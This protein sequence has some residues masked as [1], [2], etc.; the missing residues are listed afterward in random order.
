MK[1]KPKQTLGRE[2]EDLAVAHLR[3]MGFRAVDRNVRT[4]FGEIDIVASRKGEYYFVEVKARQDDSRGEA[5]E[6]FPPFRQERLRKMAMAYAQREKIADGYLHLSLLGIDWSD[7]V[8]KITF[9][10]DIS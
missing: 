6:N 8:P 4:R 10:P 7:T 1:V 3:T 9:I 2:G 5:V